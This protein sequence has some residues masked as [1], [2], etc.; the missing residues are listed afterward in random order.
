MRCCARARHG[1]LRR[2]PPILRSPPP[3]LYREEPE[4]A[5]GGGAWNLER[6]SHPQALARNV[7]TPL[8]RSP[9]RPTAGGRRPE[10]FHRRRAR[11]P[12]GPGRAGLERSLRRWDR[13]R[14][15]EGRARALSGAVAAA[16]AATRGAEMAAER[17]ARWLLSTT[18]SRRCCRPPPLLLL[19]P[20]LLLLGRAA[21]GAAAVKSGSPP[22]SA[23][24]RCGA[25]D[26]VGAGPRHR[27]PRPPRWVF[28]VV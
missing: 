17:G 5:A 16:A 28:V 11:G 2:P 27:F 7:L 1:A 24:K 4:S 19:L 6:P 8:L 25:R 21:S 14:R 18:S 13:L 12:R 26:S 23:G 20:P 15:A 10:S 3:S 22:Q 9:P